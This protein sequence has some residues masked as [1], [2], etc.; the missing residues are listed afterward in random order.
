MYRNLLYERE[1]ERGYDH[2]EDLF[3]P[4]CF[5]GRIC[6]G[7]FTLHCS[8]PENQPLQYVQPGITPS[9]PASWLD[10]ASAAFC[11]GDEIHAGYHWFRESWGRD[12]AISVNGLLIERDR[13]A[14]AQVVL[15]KLARSMKDGVIPN[16]FPDNYHTSDA[17]LWFV[18][19]VGRYRRRWGDDSFVAGMHPFIEEIMECYPSSSVATLDHSLITVARQ[20]TWMDTVYT[21]REGKP[22]EI[23]A[24][25]I[26]ALAEA[27]SMGIQVPVQVRSAKEV[28]VSFWND[29]L[30]CLYDCIDPPDPSVRPNQVI[31]LALGLV[32]QQQASAALSVIK[33]TLLT[34]YGL[35]TLSPHD[36]V[37]QGRFSG[38]RSYHNGCVWPWLTGW[39]VEALLQTGTDREMIAPMLS[40]ILNHVR[41]AGAGYISEI[42][43]GD[44]PYRPQGCIAQAWSVAEISRA[45]RMVIR[46]P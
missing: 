46:N 31:A 13:K 44:P 1:R 37:Y 32:D 41:E 11:H 28:F 30:Q 16:R 9:S 29:E 12:S 6:N 14:E 39:F 20:S 18:H 43:D 2:V 22:V 24:L 35:R 25:W 7:S 5:R 36:P 34:P 45:C 19:A 3:S 38:D 33:K 23:N 4:G 27:E 26:S 10:W 42:F 40:P 15:L 8:G 17:S 21:P